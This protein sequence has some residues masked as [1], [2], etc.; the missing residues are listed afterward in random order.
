MA[1]KYVWQV[2]GLVCETHQYDVEVEAE[3]EQGARN[4]ANCQFGITN[5]HKVRKIREVEDE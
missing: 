2:V 3:T 5:V 4:E 1:K